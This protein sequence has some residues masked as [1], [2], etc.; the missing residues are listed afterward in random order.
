MIAIF[1]RRGIAYRERLS[2]TRR[3][4]YKRALVFPSNFDLSLEPATPFKQSSLNRPPPIT[5]CTDAFHSHLYFG[6]SCMYVC[7]YASLRFWSYSDV[8]FFSRCFAEEPLGYVRQ[9]G[10]GLAGLFVLELC[11]LCK[12]YQGEHETTRVEPEYSVPPVKKTQRLP[13]L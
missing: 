1:K 2:D 6:V 13:G 4:I 9:M 12:L 8:C 10:A 11:R 7:M 3:M 5:G